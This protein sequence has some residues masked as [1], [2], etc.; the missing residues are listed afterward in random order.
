MTAT[1]KEW[2]E[3]VGGREASLR[4][5]DAPLFRAAIGKTG[6]RSPSALDAND[7]GGQGRGCFGEGNEGSLVVGRG[8][9]EG[10]SSA[11]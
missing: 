10:V 1:R 8:C 6:R 11:R 2:G 5:R 9:H 4:R 3:S 7:I